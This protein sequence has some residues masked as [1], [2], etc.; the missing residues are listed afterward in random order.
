MTPE[1]W[2]RAGLAV[3]AEIAGGRPKTLEK[4]ALNQVLDYLCRQIPASTWRK[5]S[6]NRAATHIRRDGKKAGI[7]FTGTTYNLLEIVPAIHDYIATGAASASSAAPMDEEKQQKIRKL[8]LE[9][10]IRAGR[11]VD[12]EELRPQLERVAVVLRECGD[13]LGRRFGPDGKAIL[14]TAVQNAERIVM[15][16][17]EDG[18]G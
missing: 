15:S 10:E 9:N 18:D 6:G 3:Q 14:E 16:M 17:F 13:S 8:T 11:L 4:A 7:P 12:K 5:W 2:E 1:T